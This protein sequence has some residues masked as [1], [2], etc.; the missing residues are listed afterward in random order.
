MTD[1]RRR[2]AVGVRV[3]VK[4]IELIGG[5]GGEQI[6]EDPPPFKA[7]KK[8]EKW[9]GVATLARPLPHCSQEIDVVDVAL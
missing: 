4:S 1:D 5:G 9:E 6:R 2:D 7:K 8:Q 3:C